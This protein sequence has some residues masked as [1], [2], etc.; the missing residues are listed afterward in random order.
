MKKTVILLGALVLSLTWSPTGF[1]GQ[2][3]GDNATIIVPAGAIKNLRQVLVVKG[4]PKPAA[5]KV[6]NCG[7][8]EV[9][10][11]DADLVD[12]PAPAGREGRG[13]QAVPPLPTVQT[14]VAIVI[15]G[16]AGFK[17]LKTGWRLGSYRGGG[18]C[19]PGYDVY[20]AHIIAVE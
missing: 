5:T 17:E 12:R 18:S 9:H 3:L 16:P 1:A 4:A 10:L 14:Q 11:Q 15:P 13:G 7:P 19:G 20:V 6:G 8:A 2:Q